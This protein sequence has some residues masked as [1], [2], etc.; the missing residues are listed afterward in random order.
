MARDKYHKIIREALEVDGWTVTHDPLYLTYGA[1]TMEI[2]IGAERLMAAEREGEKIAIE[3][4]SF[5]E[6]SK[7]YAFHQALGQFMV[8]RLALQHNAEDRILYLA[9]T[10]YVYHVFFKDQQMVDDA[11]EKL[12]LRLLI[13]DVFSKT[14]ELWIK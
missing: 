6:A 8:Y 13:V 14:I 11:I 10:S 2:D 1:S 4:K 5:I 7:V 12:G 3:I 9:V